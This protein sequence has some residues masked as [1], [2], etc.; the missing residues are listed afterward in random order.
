LKRD[1]LLII[2]GIIPICFIYYIL[3]YMN[4][5][6]RL[7]RFSKSIQLTSET[8]SNLKIGDDISFS[9]KISTENQNTFKEYKLASKER[10]VKRKDR[11]IWVTHETFFQT[12][13]LN[14]NDN[15]ATS[16]YVEIAPEYT[17]CGRNIW[18][19][20]GIGEE[21]KTFR[22]LGMK[23]DTEITGYGK[24]IN[25]EPLKINAGHSVCAESR[26]EYL[27]NLKNRGTGYFL[28]ML[29]VVIPS[30]FLIYLGM[31]NKRED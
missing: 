26:E 7:E 11:S 21:E 9:G 22:Y 8:I 12:L 5:D 1:Y 2:A 20:N 27:S 30:L 15:Q 29:F 6:N 28:V 14:L 13:R 31:F 17:L 24:I 19:E 10:K 25:L 18:I 23:I 16:F 3:T 4:S